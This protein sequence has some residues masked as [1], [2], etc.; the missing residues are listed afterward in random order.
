MYWMF[1]SG[2]WE[3]QQ[4]KMSGNA[5]PIVGYGI[6]LSQFLLPWTSPYNLP[7]PLSDILFHLLLSKILHSQFGEFVQIHG[8]SH[9]SYNLLQQ[10]RCIRMENI[11]ISTEGQWAMRL[12]NSPSLPLSYPSHP[13][14]TLLRL[15]SLLEH[16]YIYVDG[17][18]ILKWGKK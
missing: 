6:F 10:R 18:M 8:Q 7:I 14:W 3:W 1:R 16:G 15:P 2:R 17:R 4:Y 11:T 5:I 12:R 13:L 9:A